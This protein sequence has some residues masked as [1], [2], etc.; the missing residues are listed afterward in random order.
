MRTPKWFVISHNLHWSSPRRHEEVE[1]HE[2]LHSLFFFVPFDLLRVLRV[3]TAGMPID[4]LR[5]RALADPAERHGVA[6][7]HDAIELRTVE[8]P[9]IVI[10]ALEQADLPAVRRRREQLHL[11][12]DLATEQLR[13]LRFR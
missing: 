6:R 1:A 5:E 8:G 3:S 12:L 7:E 2:D 13:H 11:D 10:R 4:L 9:C